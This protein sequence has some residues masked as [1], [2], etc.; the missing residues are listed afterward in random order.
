MTIEIWLSWRPELT[1]TG[2]RASLGL[3]R[4][5]IQSWTLSSVRLKDSLGKIMIDFAVE[6]II[7]QSLISIIEFWQF[8]CTFCR[9][10]TRAWIEF[11]TKK[12]FQYTTR[13]TKYHLIMY[14]I[15]FYCI[16]NWYNDVKLLKENT[17][18][19]YFSDFASSLVA[20]SWL[21]LLVRQGK[22]GWATIIHKILFLIEERLWNYWNLSFETAIK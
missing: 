5:W 4:S 11:S 21:L 15:S 2:P 9:K 8:F 20:I 13:C 18:R 14:L 17:F 1:L 22:A 16:K 12:S 6:F 3:G 10:R 19:H 7:D